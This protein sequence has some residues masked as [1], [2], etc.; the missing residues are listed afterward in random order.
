MTETELFDTPIVTPDENDDSV[1]MNKMKT[2]YKLPHP[3]TGKTVYWTRA[4]TFAKSISDTYV[5]D[6]WGNRMVAKGLTL[7]PDLYA[8]TAALDVKKDRDQLNLITEEA[9]K[10]AGSKDRANLGT[11]LHA[12]AHQHDSGQSVTIPE[13][14]RP[15]LDA[16]IALCDKHGLTFNRAHMERATVVPDFG[17]AGRFDKI[18]VP[19]R[20][21]EVELAGVGTVTLAAGE[22]VILD[23]KTGADLSYGWTEI[24][25]QLAIYAHGQGLWNNSTKAL[26]PM[27]KVNQSVG[28]VIWL[29][30]GEA[31]ATLYAVNIAAGWEA[32]KL[33]QEVRNWRKTRSL[34]SPVSVTEVVPLGGGQE[35]VTDAPAPG[36]AAGNLPTPLESV[37]AAPPKT[38]AP[39]AAAKP[40]RK[41]AAK[42]PAGRPRK[43]T[44]PVGE[45]ITVPPAASVQAVP[46]PTPTD[47]QPGTVET[48]TTHE[49]T[50]ED[51][52]RAAS[53]PAELSNIRR[54]A[55]ASGQ[56]SKT[57]LD[58][59]MD[60]LSKIKTV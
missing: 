6:M 55:M 60:Q 31:K 40:A 59:G 35:V 49:P 51:R 46:D 58:L 29:P 52:I 5:L 36:D 22:G 25:I 47:V 41:T 3:E 19:S 15:D 28:L 42:R 4:T 10:S 30:V 45:T 21:L 8:L 34:A 11:A 44:A 13:Q 9:K 23:L 24:A 17:V 14:W 57:L 39:R 38:T 27:P 53:S 48:M 20:D 32:A 12:F 54:R 56:W 2:Q 33:C 18:T 50:W 1:P 26:D 16:Y 37:L 7:R 43:I